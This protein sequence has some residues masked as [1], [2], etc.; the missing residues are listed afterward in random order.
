MK[1]RKTKIYILCM[2]LLFSFLL[3]GCLVSSATEGDADG[4]QGESAPVEYRCISNPESKKKIYVILKNYHGDYWKTVI[5]G[6]EK[7]AK[8][9]DT[10]IY[11]GGIDNETDISGQIRLMNEAI[12]QGADGIL[13]APAN[14][15]S[16]VKSCAKAKKKNVSVVLID[17][18]INSTEFDACYMTDNIDA[19]KMAAKEMIKL[20]QDAGNSPTQPLEVGV[21]LSADTSQ[22]MVNRVSGF[23][24]AWTQ[25]APSQW[26]IAKD[27]FLNGGDIEK[28][29]ADAADLLEKNKNIKG[30][31]GCNNT[32]TIGIAKTLVKEKRTDI[33]MVGFD[34]AK[35][36]QQFIQD[37]DYQGVS[38]LQ[39]QDQ[40]GYL[41]IHSLVSLIKGEK[42]EQKFFD[43]GVIMVNSYYLMEKGVS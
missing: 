32:S 36:T 19:G 22:A 33:V 40:M 39:K 8:E 35:E 38:L 27:I 29:Q 9:V 11:L 28:A 10:A 31:Y 21:L 42:S 20:L 2:V 3:S 7:A 4:T 5:E 14:S 24:E 15:N 23:L 43:T 25:Y 34:M 1:C 6:V 16:L 30:F 26:D 13:L 12:E 37:A 41:G 17:S 18:A